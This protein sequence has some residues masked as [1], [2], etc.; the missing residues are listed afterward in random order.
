MT[1]LQGLRRTDANL[2]CLEAELSLTLPCAPHPRAVGCSFSPQAGRGLSWPPL[3]WGK[4][5][6]A[7]NKE[8]WEGLRYSAS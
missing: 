6:K 2:R 4:A 5:S 8:R 1:A 7:W 3:T